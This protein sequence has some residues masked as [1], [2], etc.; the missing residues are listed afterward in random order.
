M[1]FFGMI[2]TLLFVTAASDISSDA[3]VTA[4]RYRSLCSIIFYHITEIF[5]EKLP[6]G[7]IH[8]LVRF[9]TA[10]KENMKH[11]ISS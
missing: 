3:Q 1:L 4:R 7:W 8:E 10:K 11:D 5:T 6:N 9:S 2:F